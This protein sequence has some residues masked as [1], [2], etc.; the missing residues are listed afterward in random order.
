[1][2][3]SGKKIWLHRQGSGRRDILHYS[4]LLHDIGAFLSYNNH[5]LNSWY[6]IKNADLLGFNNREISLIA[7]NAFF[8]RRGIPGRKHSQTAGIDDRG[9]ETIKIHAILIRIAESLDRSHAGLIKHARFKLGE[10]NTIILE[11]E[12]DKNC[13]LEIW[14]AQNHTEAFKK[15]F[16]KKLEI[17]RL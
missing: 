17:K 13:E 12:S 4:A 8:H 6:F 15:I 1:M 16:G 10:K 2:F 14:G 7:A 9:L 3:D 11:L 5:H